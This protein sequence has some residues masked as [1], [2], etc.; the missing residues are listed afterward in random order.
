MLDKQISIL[1][2]KQKTVELRYQLPFNIENDENVEFKTYE[3]PRNLLEEEFKICKAN[4]QRTEF[5]GELM[6]YKH[7]RTYPPLE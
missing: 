3:E 4:M 7:F 2:R 5:L 6:F 1:K